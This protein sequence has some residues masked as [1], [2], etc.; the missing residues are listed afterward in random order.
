MLYFLRACP[1]FFHV[2]L[3]NLG[4][5]LL[6]GALGED[7]VLREWKSHMKFYLSTNNSFGCALSASNGRIWFIRIIK[8]KTNLMQYGGQWLISGKPGRCKPNTKFYPKSNSMPCF[9]C[10]CNDEGQPFCPTVDYKKHWILVKLE[11]GEEGTL[12]LILIEILY[13]FFNVIRS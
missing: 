4:N 3:V 2:P 13:T 11:E 12:M 7:E 10:S 6:R 8:F 9:E 1:I 5:P